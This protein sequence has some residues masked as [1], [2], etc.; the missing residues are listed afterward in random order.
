MRG[1]HG[2][3]LG[4]GLAGFVGGG[5]G[6]GVLLAVVGDA[7][8]QV[9]VGLELVAVLKVEHARG[10]G[11]GESGLGVGEELGPE[12]VG[13]GEADGHQ[14]GGV[15]LVGIGE[16]LVDQDDLF[17]AGVGGARVFGHH[18]RSRSGCQGWMGALAQIAWLRGC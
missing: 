9:L 6:R 1:E 2:G 12:R 11:D 5:G 16:R 10:D 18:G 4:T 15:G 17:G 14:D 3:R 8:Q 7:V 13:G